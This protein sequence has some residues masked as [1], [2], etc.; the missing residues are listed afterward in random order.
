MKT[1]IV[2][3]DFSKEAENALLYAAGA[4]KQLKSKVIIFNSYTVPSHAGNSLFPASGFLELI[5]YNNNILK[6]KALE[7]AEEFSIEVGYESSLMDVNEELEVLIKKHEADLVIMGMAPKSLN[8][9]LFGNTTTSAI[10]NFKFPV[11]AIPLGAKFTGVKKI[12]FACD[13]LRGVEQKMLERIKA[14]T[15][16]MGAEIEIFSVHQ[17]LKALKEDHLLRIGEALKEVTHS[18]KNIE[19]SEIIREIEKEVKAFEADL[20]IMIPHKYNFWS[21]IVHQSKT[22]IMASTSEVPLLSIAF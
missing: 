3:T 9:D 20:L 19:S 1:I 21:S 8:Q 22:R 12:L 2:A 4:A 14:F 5:E 16:G 13:I 18:Y 10:T 17:K 11:L 6:Q 7:L 15:A